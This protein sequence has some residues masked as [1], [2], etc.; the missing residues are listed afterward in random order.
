MAC[1]EF[2]TKM[3]ALDEGIVEMARKALEEVDRN[4]SGL[5]VG[6]Q[7]EHFSAGA[8][9]FSIAALAGNGEW[10]GIE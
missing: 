8:N 1:L 6:N 9:V 2:H 3:N 5:V 4:F 10:D 7:G